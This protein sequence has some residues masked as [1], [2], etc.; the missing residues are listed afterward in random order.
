MS[1]RNTCVGRDGYRAG[2]TGDNHERDSS[3]TAGDRFLAAAP[4][5]KRI[6]AFKSSDVQAFAG[7]VNQ[8]SVDVVLIETMLSRLLAR[9]DQFGVGAGFAQQLMR[10]EAVVDH[11]I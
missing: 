5:N 10:C 6:A 9:I 2:D 1:D 11:H 3:V 8:Q 4:K 7:A